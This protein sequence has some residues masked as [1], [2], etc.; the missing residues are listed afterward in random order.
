MHRKCDVHLSIF[1]ICAA[2]ASSPH[3]L[4]PPQLLDTQRLKFYV[5]RH[6]LSSTSAHVESLISPLERKQRETCAIIYFRCAG[7]G[8]DDGPLMAAQSRITDS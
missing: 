4:L 6:S 3:F 1:F 8:C 2:R 5:I 7:I